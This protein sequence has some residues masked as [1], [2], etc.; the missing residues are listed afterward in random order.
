MR[1]PKDEQVHEIQNHKVSRRKK[2]TQAVVLCHGKASDRPHMSALASGSG[3]QHGTS[4][5]IGIRY[6]TNSD[7][8]SES[9]SLLAVALFSLVDQYSLPQPLERAASFVAKI[10]FRPY[11][12]PRTSGLTKRSED[13]Q[14]RVMLR[15]RD[16]DTVEVADRLVSPRRSMEEV[17]GEPSYLAIFIADDN[18]ADVT[19]GGDEPGPGVLVL[20]FWQG[21]LVEGKVLPPSRSPLSVVSGFEWSDA[22]FGWD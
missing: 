8:A 16:K 21:G 3:P 9:Y 10:S 4:V 20:G 17:V 15:G 2:T 14:S 1:E 5:G 11:P 18:G 13:G 6:C 19:I 7:C 22:H 12:A